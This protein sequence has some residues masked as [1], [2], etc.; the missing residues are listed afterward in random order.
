MKTATEQEEIIND[1]KNRVDCHNDTGRR[2]VSWMPYLS[3]FL[4]E[5]TANN[6]FTVVLIANIC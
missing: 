2:N 1:E 5:G 4:F 3:R 6:K